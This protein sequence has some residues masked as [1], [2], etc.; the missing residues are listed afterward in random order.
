MCR[1]SAIPVLLPVSLLR[2]S[3][4]HTHTHAYIEKQEGLSL[5][6]IG[7]RISGL[8][9]DCHLSRRE[10]FC[11]SLCA[12]ECSYQLGLLELVDSVVLPEEKESRRA[13]ISLHAQQVK[14]KKEE[15]VLSFFFSLTQFFCGRSW[16][17]DT[18]FDFETV[19]I[20]RRETP[21]HASDESKPIRAVTS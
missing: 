9:G 21:G 19:S 18:F 17:F 8:S 4:T 7:H 13:F 15:L 20:R 16:F 10:Y 5:L 6:T 1:L 2:I 14:K 12:C 11:E 3:N